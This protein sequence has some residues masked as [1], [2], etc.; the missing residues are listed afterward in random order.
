[1]YAYS[2]VKRFLL[3][4]SLPTSA[5]VHERLSNAAGLAVLASDALSSVA[6][7]TQ[8]TLLVL[9]LAGSSSLSLSLP[10][11]GIIILLLAIVALSYRQTI[12][13]YPNGGGAYIV[14]RENLGIYPGSIA[15][16]SL[17]IDYILTV[18]VSIS[19]GVAALTSAFP[20]LEPY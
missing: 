8:E 13:A 19:V 15:A 16:A 18:T 6:Y 7:A 11:S 3:G 2:R 14:A 5:S 1:M 17:M 12:K 20:G 10:I 9:L 4:E